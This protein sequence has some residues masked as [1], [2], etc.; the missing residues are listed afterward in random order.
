MR[1][2]RR[3]SVSERLSAVSD[4]LVEAVSARVEAVS[5]RIEQV[6]RVARPLIPNALRFTRRSLLITSLSAPLAM[7][8]AALLLTAPAQDVLARWAPV[9]ALTPGQVPAGETT[10]PALSVAA[11]TA[12]PRGTPDPDAARDTSTARSP[13]DPAP[14]LGVLLAA[15]RLTGV[16]ATAT[17]D[18][19]L[20]QAFGGALLRPLQ[21][22]GRDGQ[23]RVPLELLALDDDWTELQLTLALPPGLRYRRHTPDRGLHE[24]GAAFAVTAE[25]DRL[26]LTLTRV[27]DS[28]P[29]PSG[30]LATLHLDVAP[31]ALPSLPLRCGPLVRDGQDQ[32]SPG[33][34]RVFLE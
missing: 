22:W 23:A 3:D 6:A 12:T 28:D 26:T 15:D 19:A 11:T 18:E 33:L 27:A 20:A 4:R 25:R 30:P 1:P 31:D 29:V 17:E 24:S 7:L 21:A 9:Q 2:T 16:P 32:G 14:G 8:C 34:G 10:A 5:A 13:S